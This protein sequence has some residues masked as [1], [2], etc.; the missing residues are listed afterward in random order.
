MGCGLFTRENGEKIAEKKRMVSILI[1]LLKKDKDW[2][3]RKWATFAL[4][5]IGEKA[6]EKEKVIAALID[7]LEDKD[8]RVRRNA[9]FTLGY[10]EI[11]Q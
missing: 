3:V 6:P 10:I 11:K 2:E 4:G 7:A 9:T 1:K 5:E 8:Y